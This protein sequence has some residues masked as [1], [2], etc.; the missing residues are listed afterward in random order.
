MGNRLC[1]ACRK[2]GDEF[3]PPKD[4][5]PNFHHVAE[6]KEKEPTPPQTPEPTPPFPDP[7]AKVVVAIYHYDARTDDDLSF[8]KGD[9]L[10]VRDSNGDWW[11]ARDRKTGKKGYI[12][13]NY[14]APL[15]SLEAE[16]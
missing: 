6:E 12:P 5:G 3:V 11:Y 10:E 15:Q 13:C 2:R 9:T 1:K 7:R 14:V 8:Q 4:D 16:P